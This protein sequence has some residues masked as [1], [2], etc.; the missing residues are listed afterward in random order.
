[1]LLE[2]TVVEQLHQQILARGHQRNERQDALQ[3]CLEKLAAGQRA[4]ID[5]YYGDYQSIQQI[6]ASRSSTPNAIYKALRRIRAGLHEC[7]SQRLA[8]EGMS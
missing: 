3:H 8:G 5:S 2:D 1:M 7:I 6:A 4:M